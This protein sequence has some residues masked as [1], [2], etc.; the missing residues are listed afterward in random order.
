MEI[1]LLFRDFAVL[2]LKVYARRTVVKL[3]THFPQVDG[4]ARIITVMT[5]TL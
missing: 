3:M 4:S 2:E 1:E 5:P